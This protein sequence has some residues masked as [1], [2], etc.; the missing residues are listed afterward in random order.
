M[1]NAALR[2][3]IYIP[4]SP[5]ETKP[6]ID[7]VFV[8]DYTFTSHIVHMKLKDVEL[9]LSNDGNLHPT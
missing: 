7:K 5:Y 4:H 8:V 3:I 1:V 2:S 9:T 6:N